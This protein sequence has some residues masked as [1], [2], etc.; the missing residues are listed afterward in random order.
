MKDVTS[1]VYDDAGRTIATINAMGL[2]HHVDSF[3]A[4]GQP[5]AVYECQKVKP[6]HDC[7]SIRPGR[8]VG[9]TINP[10]GFSH[11]PSVMTTPNRR[12]A[13]GTINPLSETSTTVYDSAGRTTGQINP[14][15]LQTVTNYDKA[16][17]VISTVT[18]LGFRATTVYDDAGRT[19]P[20]SDAAGICVHHG[21]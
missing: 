10:L 3:D 19:N 5:T 7:L 4:A 15:G 14:L 11:Q 17:R 18:P 21:V 9:N 13:G 16:D 2:C 8:T 1:T 20:D 12:I 6:R